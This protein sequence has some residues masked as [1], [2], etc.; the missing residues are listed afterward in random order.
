[1]W[2]MRAGMGG[3][4]FAPLYELLIKRGVTVNFFNRV[5][6]VHTDAE[7]R[8]VTCIEV[9]VQ[10]TMGTHLPQDLLRPSI[11]TSYTDGARWPSEPTVPLDQEPPNLK[12]RTDYESY[13]KPQT[14][15]GTKTLEL[16][17]HFDRVVYAMPISTVPLI[18]P[19]LL[20]RWQGAV[21]HI[22][23]VPTQAVQLWLKQPASKL[24]EHADGAIV[25]GFT[26]PFDTWADMDQLAGE[27]DAA[28]VA[29]LCNV[30]PHSTLPKRGTEEAKRFLR[31]QAA[32]VRDYT[33]R[34]L[35][36]DV[37]HLWPRAVDPVTGQ[38]DWDLLVD[39]DN[40]TGEERL[41]AQYLRANVEPSERYVLSVPGSSAYRI[42]PGDTGFSN[43]YAAGDWT[44]CGL[45]NGCVE[46]ATISG[47]LAANAIL[48]DVGA[49]AHIRPIIGHPCP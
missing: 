30:L 2:K 14:R 39:P 16:G 48:A 49:T 10:A 47:L 11:N 17:R 31:E 38:L 45:D 19:E 21:D 27:K 25:G 8:H 12:A 13:L 5:E 3:I 40:G 32:L 1:M 20:H 35:R 42:S 44:R 4:V 43:L 34:F 6:K 9:D 24:S 23:T 36:E 15:V 29:Y 26:E 22:E 18:A 33:A 46:A 28:T 37:R 41:D 7:H